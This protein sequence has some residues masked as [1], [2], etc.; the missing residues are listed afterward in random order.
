VDKRK[1]QCRPLFSW[2]WQN[3]LSVSGDDEDFSMA[4]GDDEDFSEAKGDDEVFSKADGDNEDSL[5]ANQKDQFSYYDDDNDDEYADPSWE[6]PRLPK[7][8][9]LTQP[10]DHS[11]TKGKLSQ[12]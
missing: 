2:V 7:G 8:G 3:W 9:V 4:K 10:S 1:Q 12:I 5:K 11:I 6:G